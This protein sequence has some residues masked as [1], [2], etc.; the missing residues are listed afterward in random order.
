MEELKA[1]CDAMAEELAAALELRDDAKA[2]N[3]LAA[4]NLMHEIAKAKKA[5]ER[6]SSTINTF[7]AG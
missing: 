7:F 6:V 2:I 3:E 5:V 1:K 4:I